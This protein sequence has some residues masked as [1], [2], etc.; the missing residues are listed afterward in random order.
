MKI[1]R[2]TIASYQMPLTFGLRSGAIITLIGNNGIKSLGD[3]APLPNWSQETLAQAI[4]EFEKNKNALLEIDWSLDNFLKK[5]SQFEFFSSSL[6]FGLESA[7]STWLDPLNPFSMPVSALFLGPPHQIMEQAKIRHLEN[8]KSAKLKVGHLSF[9]DAEKLIHQLKDKFHLRIDVNRAWSTSDSLKFFA[10][11]SKDAF[12]Y[13]EE[14]FQSPLDLHLFEHPLAI[15]E[16]YPANFSLE[17]LSSLPTLKAIV[18]KP[19][20]QGG[21]GNLL[22]LKAFVDENHLQLVLSSSFESDL[23]LAHIAGMAKRLSLK[24][25]LGIGTYHHIKR[26]LFPN[27]IKCENARVCWNETLLQPSILDTL[28]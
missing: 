8:F 13:V 19:T 12:D 20:I 23:G 15:D 22:P 9:D 3:V 1:D 21:L 4:D 25:P 11:F 28:P 6:I 17:R 27:T 14:P 2:L 7:L 5:L 24:A 16:S 18:Y 26:Y 10:K